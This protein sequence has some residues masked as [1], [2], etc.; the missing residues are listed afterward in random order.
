[1]SLL[2]KKGVRQSLTKLWRMTRR[3]PPV[4]GLVET[5][6]E[7]L[8]E[9]IEHGVG[10]EPTQ[11]I[12]ELVVEDPGRRVLPMKVRPRDATFRRIHV[13]AELDPV[14][15]LSGIAW[16]SIGPFADLGD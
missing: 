1:M 8:S 9:L 6:G 15:V 3:L 11:L 14:D 12:V 13:D 16:E 7:Q 4:H 10:E 5:G 2:A